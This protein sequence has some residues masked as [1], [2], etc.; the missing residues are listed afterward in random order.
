MR[1]VLVIDDDLGTIETFAAILGHSGFIVSTAQ[2]GLHGLQAV[3]SQHHDV[4]LLDLRLPDMTGL[5]VL[6]A[7]VTSR[8][9]V[10]CVIMSAFG[11][12][13]TAVEAMRMGACNFVEKP[14]TDGDIVAI[15]QHAIR[16]T[17]GAC[18]QSTN[19]RV[20]EA[21]YLISERAHAWGVHGALMS[22]YQARDGEGF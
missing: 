16:D 9:P 4:V 7:L 8:N 17:D 1:R 21:M 19:W 2:T 11:S 6:Q 13:G 12:I 18:N 15:V 22:S 5:E 3:L 14:L 20:A 10:P